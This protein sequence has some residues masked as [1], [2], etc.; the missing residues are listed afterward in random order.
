MD[1][2]IQ[3]YITKCELCLEHKYE[4]KAYETEKYGP[5]IANRPL[6][7]IHVDIFHRYFAL[8]HNFSDKIITVNGSDFNSTLFKEFCR[9]HKIEYHQTTINRHTLNG[10][11]ERL[12]LTLREKL[13]ILVGQNPQETIKN[14]MTTAILIYTQPGSD[15]TEKYNGLRKNEIFPFYDE[16]YKGEKQ[17]QKSPNDSKNKLESKKIY[18]KS[19][20]QQRNKIAPGYPKLLVQKRKSH[21][22]EKKMTVLRMAVITIVS[23]ILVRS[24]E[25]NPDATCYDYQQGVER[26]I[27]KYHYVHFYINTSSLR[28]CQLIYQNDYVCY[29]ILAED[30]KAIIISTNAHLA[31][32]YSLSNKLTIIFSKYKK[33]KIENNK[34]RVMFY[35]TIFLGGNNLLI[36]GHRVDANLGEFK[37]L[38]VQP[39][40]IEN[41][42]CTTGIHIIW[43]RVPCVNKIICNCHGNSNNWNNLHHT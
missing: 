22:L 39:L 42:S 1:R 38:E 3:N 29:Q 18:V 15:V 35:G 12:H 20:Q 21:S 10:P 6:Q 41:S 25:I 43:N 31:L 5:I 40:I 23:T 9:I 27:G 2:F 8:H 17:K 28:R 24:E 14:R 37:T 13:S 16:L 11:I 32:A 19:H 36:Q 26:I 4:R 34:N 33:K 7:H 30:S